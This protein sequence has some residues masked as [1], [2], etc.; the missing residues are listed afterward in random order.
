MKNENWAYAIRPYGI[1]GGDEINR[2]AN[3]IRVASQKLVMS[4]SQK[5]VISGISNRRI[6][7]SSFQ[8][9]YLSLEFK[10]LSLL[11]TH[12]SLNS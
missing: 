2:M 5:L 1:R 4:A 6:F 12:Y 3:E 11:T 8:R 7:A 10:V 9:E